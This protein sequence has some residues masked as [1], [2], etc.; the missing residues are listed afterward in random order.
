MKKIIFHKHLHKHFLALASLPKKHF[1]HLQHKLHKEHRISRNTLFY[2]KEYGS[3]T[4]VPKTILKESIKILLLASLLSSIGGFALE[5]IKS[6][7]FSIIPLVI[8]FPVLNDMIGDYGSIFSAKFSTMLHEGKIKASAFYSPELK[9]LFAQILVIAVITTLFSCLIAFSISF[10]SH[11]LFDYSVILKVLLIAL[12]DVILLVSI[13]F[14]VSIFG[15][16]YFFKKKE[17]PSNFLIPIT[18]SI[19]DF[20]NILILSLLVIL[21][22]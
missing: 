11:S 18:T 2:M 8:L 17:D 9:K 14:L 15:G 6:V 3:H 13:L 19:A 21:L 1:H 12:L 5:S 7:L 10:F 16:L 22:F 20:G 4:N